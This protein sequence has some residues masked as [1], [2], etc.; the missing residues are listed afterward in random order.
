M[1]SVARSVYT[2]T[3]EAAAPVRVETVSAPTVLVP[4]PPRPAPSAPVVRRPTSQDDRRRSF[5]R[6]VSHE[7]RTPLNSVIGFS[8]IIHRELYG[9][10][11][12]SKYRDHAGVIRESGLKLLKLVNQVLEI[13]RL[14]AGTADL[15]LQPE[16][17]KT[18]VTQVVNALELEAAARKVNFRVSIDPATPLVLADPRGLTTILTNLLQNAIAFSPEG[19]EVEV[20]VHP[21]G[22]AVYFRITD[23][24]QGV[25]PADIPRLMLPFEQ[26]EN[27]L[28]RRGEGA[29]LGLPIVQLLCMD[30]GGKLRLRSSPGQ[31]LTALVRLVAA[32]ASPDES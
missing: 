6:M 21:K 9:P 24:G 1:S 3:P 11:G 31:G 22:G 30:M 5:L 2:E 15:V 13:A 16:S 20:D 18:A 29:G 28:T 17:P 12:N 7:L 14:D 32:S 19:G 27:V 8:E 23:H 10:M 4:L 26:G 25:A